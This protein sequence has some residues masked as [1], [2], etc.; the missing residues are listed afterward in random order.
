[1]R[2]RMLGAVLAASCLGIGAVA[3]GSSPA[4]ADVIACQYLQ[5]GA[6][7]GCAKVPAPSSPT[8]LLGL[9]AGNETVPVG[10][11]QDPTTTQT[12]V[13]A[14]SGSAGQTCVGQN[15][16]VPALFSVGAVTT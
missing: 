6:T 4:S 9:E 8:G 16:G 3:L 1:M 14:L 12:F 13:C 10:P 15:L 7:L 11:G 5:Y 2:N